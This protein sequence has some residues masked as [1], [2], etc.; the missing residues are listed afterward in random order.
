MDAVVASTLRFVLTVELV[1]G[2]GSVLI[3]TCSWSVVGFQ[4]RPSVVTPSSLSSDN[5]GCVSCSYVGMLF[6]K[7]G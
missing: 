4:S 6:R 2:T 3:L 7:V 1:D 5:V